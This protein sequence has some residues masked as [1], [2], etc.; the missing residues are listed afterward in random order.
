MY[1][2][3]WPSVLVLAILYKNIWRTFEIEFLISFQAL[4]P[5]QKLHVL[6][7]NLTF[8]DEIEF[9]VQRLLLEQSCDPFNTSFFLK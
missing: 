4:S 3:Q 5:S 2:T 7:K 6:V 9:N 1:F 8:A